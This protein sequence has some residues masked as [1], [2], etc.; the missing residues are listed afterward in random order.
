MLYVVKTVPVA[1]LV[2]RLGT[3]KKISRE[4]VINESKLVIS[5]NVGLD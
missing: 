3:G 2:Q 5:L 4:S 1:D